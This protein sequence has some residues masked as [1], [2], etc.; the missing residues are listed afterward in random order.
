MTAEANDGGPPGD[1][2]GTD[3][4]DP[5]AAPVAAD[6]SV[7]NTAEVNMQVATAKRW[8]RSIVKFKAMALAMATLDEET[9]A[10]CFYALPRAGRTI[11]GPSVRLAEIVASAWM[12][13]RIGAQT[14]RE[15]EQ[16]VYASA[17]AWDL[18]RNV[19]IQFESRRRIVDKNGRR[20]NADMIAVTANAAASIALRNAIF[21]IVPMAYVRPIWAAARKVAVG[22]LQTLASKRGTMLDYF[23]TLGIDK[24]RILSRLQRAGV[25]D[26]D[27]EDLATLKGVAT[28]V[29]DGTIG[30][31]NAFPEIATVIPDTNGGK[32]GFGFKGDRSDDPPPA[33]GDDADTKAEAKAQAAALRKQN[34][35]QR[36]AAKGDADPAP[37]GADDAKGGTDADDP[38]SAEI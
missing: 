10:S 12:N 21:K 9:A 4:L 11:E 29:K 22:D 30:L 34:R 23:A 26:I 27:L 35:A 3:L 17:V 6:L 15:D 33:D 8:P 36:K 28:G 16:F 37:D 19:A 25:E 2:P 5:E 32:A 31:D 38:D 14:T 24:A 1:G 20:F 7:V 13:L 18:E